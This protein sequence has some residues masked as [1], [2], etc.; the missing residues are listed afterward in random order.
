MIKF[1]KIVQI[2]V[3]IPVILVMG[4]V[5]ALILFGPGL[6]LYKVLTQGDIPMAIAITFIQSSIWFFVLQFFIER[7][8]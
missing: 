5:L 4:T 2:I 3:A 1:L 8:E 7:Y 6:L